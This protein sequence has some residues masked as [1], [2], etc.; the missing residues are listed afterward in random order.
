MDY[1]FPFGLG[2]DLAGVVAAVGPGVTRWQVGDQ[3]F[4]MSNQRNGADRTYAE[5]RVA[6]PELLAPLPEAGATSTPRVY[7]WRVAPSRSPMRWVRGSR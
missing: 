5:Y 6:S 2:F 7:R 3:V 4:G 1:H